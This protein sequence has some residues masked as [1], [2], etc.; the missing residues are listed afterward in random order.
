MSLQVIYALNT[1]NDEHE[2]IVQQIKEQHEEEMQQ[3]LK[4][5]KE[6]LTV[7]KAKVDQDSNQNQRIQQLESSLREY[8]SIKSRH[9]SQFE[10]FKKTADERE[11][12][13]KAEHAQKMLELSH[14]VL[15]TKKD[16]EEKLRQFEAWK[17]SVNDEHQKR[18]S[19]LREEHEK[20]IENVRSHFKDQNND[21]L[22]EVKKVEDKYKGEIENL[23]IKYKEL[24]ES[25]SKMADDYEAKLAKAQLFYEKE[26]EAVM[27]QNNVS[28]DEAN[29]L[30][31]E[32]KERLKKE[33]AA[34]E[35]DLRKQLNSALSQLT[36]KEDL[37]EALQSDLKTLSGR[38]DE[39]VRNSEALEQQ[40][41]CSFH[42]IS[43][44]W[45]CHL[46]KKGSYCSAVFGRTGVLH[47]T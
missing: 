29:R 43:Q 31:M 20:E 10:E 22:N 3:L 46:S 17:D 11:M 41:S 15:S 18:I 39:K 5:T 37:V 7:Y 19:A 9:L 12:K 26:L 35:A 47:N 13:L 28:Q 36:E 8:E 23:H 14:D 2:A 40:V 25:K 21:W 4:E 33:F 45:L 1:K 42:F 30:L 24:E 16:F 27:K 32:E 34:Q 38:L 44:V 6:K